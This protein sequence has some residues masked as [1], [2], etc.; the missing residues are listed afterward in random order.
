[1]L[2]SYQ[3]RVFVS[4]RFA[5]NQVELWLPPASGLPPAS[6]ALLARMNGAL[7]EISKASKAES[8]INRHFAAVNSAANEL[9]SL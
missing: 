2:P 1:L 3:L 8:L 5:A 9:R 4:G 6:V 7:H